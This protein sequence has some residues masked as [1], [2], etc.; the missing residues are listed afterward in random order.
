M[1]DFII[2]VVRIVNKIGDTKIKTAAGYANINNS[3]NVCCT[4]NAPR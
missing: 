1:T 2:Y 3:G 4:N